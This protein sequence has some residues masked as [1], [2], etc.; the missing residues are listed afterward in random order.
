MKLKLAA[1]GL[2]V[3]GLGASAFAMVGP[4]WASN[5]SAKY[6]T[7]Q[8]TVGAVS[9]QSVA[10]GTIAAS[11]VYGLKFGATPDIVS[12]NGTASGSGSSS[13]S[14][15]NS[16]SSGA[17]SNSA[18]NSSSGSALTW[19]V[20]TATA[21][22]GQTVKK[23]DV[24]ATAD[25]SA[26]QLQLTS[27]QATLASAQAKLTTDK[28][29]PS[30]TVTTQARDSVNQAQNS[31]NQ[32]VANQKTTQQQNALTLT[33][34]QAAVTS[35]QAKLNTD[36]TAAALQQTLD[37][38]QSALAQA[39]AALASTQLK[40]DQSNQQAAQQ[41]TNA[42]LQLASAQHQYDLKVAPA[43]NATVL[44]DQAQ[45]DSAQASVASAQ[46][47]VAAATI[48]APSDGLIVAVN[49][50]AG[51]N[52]PS[53]HAIE[54]S[55]GPMVANASFAEATIAGLKTG[56][57]ATVAVT[58]AKQSVNGT[59]T[60]IVPVAS[61]A[62]SSSG[63]VTYTVTVT[64]TNPPAT[65]LSG[66]SAVVTVTT[67]SV[68]NVLRVPATALQGSA[69]AGYSVQIMGGN[70]SVTTQPVA[71]GLVTTSYAQVTSG[72]TQGQ[73]VVVGTATARTGTTTTGGSTGLGGLTGGNLTGGAGG[74]GR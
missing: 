69:T 74:F 14:S 7:A 13:S 45:V 16:S 5:S 71:V 38:D 15:S 67:S 25:D 22:V 42:Q 50:L 4:I 12:S 44:A 34:A 18:S 72:I 48:T 20:K 46:A 10:T 30:A 9:A 40:V 60:Q 33:Q 53:G 35:A 23:G 51:V 57:A 52:A 66:M 1:L 6:I 26:A 61:S 55:V 58:A 28:G 47:A 68:A 32:A 37:Q 31:L 29:G 17:S 65:V 41:V 21:S 8:A 70:G 62:G 11:T 49:I 36:T 63:V 43:A 59:L 3:V 64:L 2:I 24:L 27:A 56:Q 39:Q 54:E 19:P 73:E